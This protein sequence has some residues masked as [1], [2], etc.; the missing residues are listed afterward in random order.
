MPKAREL[1]DVEKF[2]IE[3]N[4]DKTDSHI[5]S[6]MSGVGVKTISKY[7]NELPE[8]S[9]QSESITETRQERVERL[10]GGP[11][12]GELISKRD[13]SIIMTQQASEVSDARKIVMGTSPTE[14][15]VDQQNRNQI[16][17]PKS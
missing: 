6:L 2:Y 1:T 14:S 12:S 8:D 10:A 13:G 5:A 17:R 16:H 15:Q 7:R 11:K 4:S 9:K 3:N